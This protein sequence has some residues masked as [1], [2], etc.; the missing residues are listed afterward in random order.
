MHRE[1]GA[2][3]SNGGTSV[4]ETRVGQKIRLGN[5]VGG[6]G[7]AR[8]RRCAKLLPLAM[9][10]GHIL[11]AIAMCRACETFLETPTQRLTAAACN[12]PPAAAAR[13]KHRIPVHTL[14]ESPS[15]ALH[16]V[17]IFGNESVPSFTPCPCLCP[18]DTDSGHGHGRRNKESQLLSLSSWPRTPNLT[19]SSRL[20]QIEITGRP[21]TLYDLST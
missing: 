8:E 16:S 15:Q 13:S 9:G 18:A 12:G 17:H 21:T 3:A 11:A 7:E 20:T 10:H 1:E 14:R 4:K 5:E 6:L 2:L 19:D